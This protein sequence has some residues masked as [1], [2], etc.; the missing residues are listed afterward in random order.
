MSRVPVTSAVRFAIRRRFHPMQRAG[1]NTARG[2]STISQTALGLGLMGLGTL[3]RRQNRGTLLYRQVVKPGQSLHVKA[4][5]GDRLVGDT[6][7]GN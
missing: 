3:L 2:A 5:S 1:W 6:T 4:F 7:V